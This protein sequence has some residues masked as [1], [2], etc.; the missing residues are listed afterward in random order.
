MAQ[1]EWS[2]EEFAEGLMLAPDERVIEGTRSNVFAV[3]NQVL[4]TPALESAGIKGIMRDVI[5]EMAK[6]AGVS[7]QELDLA[8]DIFRSADEIF[9][10][11]SIIRVWPVIEYLDS[12]YQ[13][14]P[15]TTK[16]MNMIESQLGEYE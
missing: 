9:V 7:V 16:I 12:N 15:V 8:H 6:R 10:C 5:I 13:R 1:M 11:N 4:L 2:E 14:G 3:K